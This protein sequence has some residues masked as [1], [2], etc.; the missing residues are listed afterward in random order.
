MTAFRRTD[1]TDAP[2]YLARYNERRGLKPSPP[3]S[4]P[5]DENL[6]LY[7]RR[8]RERG[9]AAAAPSA[10]LEVDGDQFTPEY[11]GTTRDKEIVAPPE[12]KPQ[13]DFAT[14]I[15]IIRHGITQG[16]STD[17]RA[18][19]DGRLAGAPARAQP[20]QERAPR[21]E[22]PDRLRR[23]QPGP[24]DRRPDLPRHADG[25]RQWEREADIGQPEPIPELRNFGVWT[26]DG[27][28]DVTSA[29]RQY[30]ALMEKLERMA[31]GDRPRWL[32]EI[33]RFYRTQLGG[34]DPI[35]MWLT[36]P[37]MYFEP[38]Q[39]CVRRFWRGF[40]RLMAETPGHPDH[41]RH[42][43]GPDPRVRHL[44][45]RLRPGRAVQHRG[46]RG[47]D[48]PRRRHRPGGLPQPGHRGERPPARRDAHLGL[49]ACSAPPQHPPLQT[50]PATSA[51]VGP[52]RIIASVSIAASV[53]NCFSTYPELGATQV[54]RELGVA[55]STAC[56]MLSA[57]AASGLLD[58]ASGGRYRLSLRMFELGV[59]AAERMPVRDA[60][61][62]V[63]IELQ[64]QVREMVQLGVPVAGH[65]AYIDRYGHAALGLQLSGETLHRVPGYSSSSGRALAAFDDGILADTLAVPRRKHTPFTITDPERLH[66]VLRAARE[67]G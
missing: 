47:A 61:R 58:R 56:R 39:S 24:A 8:F 21:A 37:L 2:H 26:P 4:S 19:P 67:A 51:P 6:P 35:S 1:R 40:H 34:A 17:C 16:Y 13:E 7:L 57:L 30:Q 41:R 9:A 50:P 18:D 14:E 32:V 42:P 15:R 48:P 66:R 63:L 38:P 44:G 31:V 29:F 23:H 53:L 55:K 54:A 10:L 25:L 52:I 27:P 33:D 64:Q 5:E 20:V 65:V 36:I 49:T 60:A 12:R 45:A 28:R 11:A 22:G 3:P 46:G 59:L 62:P 43:L